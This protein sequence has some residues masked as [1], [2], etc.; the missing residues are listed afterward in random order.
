MKKFFLVILFLCVISFGAYGSA[1]LYIKSF[2]LKLSPSKSYIPKNVEFNLQN[3]IRWKND[4][5]GTTNFNMGGHGCLVS[6][7]ATSFSELGVKVDAGMLNK[8]FS[9]KGIYD[10]NGEVIWFK[11]NE[12]YPE[13]KY[14]Y[15]RVFYSKLFEKELEEGKL[16]IVMVKYKKTGV[17]HWVLMVGSYKDDFLIIDPL[18]QSKNISSLSI[19][20]NI[21]AYRILEKT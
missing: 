3:D 14:R 17:Y 1:H 20:G 19:H 8:E 12:K 6:V 18:N 2:G 16:P 9:D 7:L 15:G 13:I 5:M 4:L 10:H 11:I 21:F